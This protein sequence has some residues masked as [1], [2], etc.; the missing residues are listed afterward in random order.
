MNQRPIHHTQNLK[1]AV[2][3]NIERPR[4]PDDQIEKILAMQAASFKSMSKTN[5]HSSTNENRFPAWL[6]GSRSWATSAALIAVITLLASVWFNQ[7]VDYTRQIALEA[8]E[9]HLYLKPLD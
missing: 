3:E 7:P 6:H 4:L 5:I 8:V 2:R 1:N 9:N